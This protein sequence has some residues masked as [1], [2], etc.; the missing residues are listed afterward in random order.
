MDLDDSICL[1]LGII[2]GFCIA[3]VVLLGMIEC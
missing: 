2:L 1:L 3:S